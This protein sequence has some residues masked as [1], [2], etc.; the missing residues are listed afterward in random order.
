MKLDGGLP[1]ELEYFQYDT[2]DDPGVRDSA[3]LWIMDQ[4]G[5]IALPR[6][7]LDAIGS[8]WHRPNLQLN[9]I[10]A[11]GRSAN[12]W[13]SAAGIVRPDLQGRATVRT[14]G[15]L[16]FQCHEPFRHWSLHFDGNI[17]LSGPGRSPAGTSKPEPL[18]FHLD[19]YMCAPPWLMGGLSGEAAAAMHS[20]GAAMLMGGVR[21]EQ[22]C[23]VRGWLRLDHRDYP[24]D[25]TGMR[26]RRRGVRQ[27]SPALGHCQLSALFPSGKA[28]GAIVM[29][30]GPAEPPVFSEAFLYTPHEGRTPARIVASP[31]M[32]ELPSRDEDATLVLDTPHGTVTIE[33][34]TLLTILDGEHFEMAATAVLQQGTARYRW[35]GEE[36]IGLIERCALRSALG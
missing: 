21:Y 8:A 7:T 16:R 3:T 28:F 19:A 11:D 18:S 23:R 10:L 24:I 29:A 20:G 35:G 17:T 12:L 1:P 4:G 9:L 6:V 33:G 5:L 31:W 36:T 22:L 27:M 30:Q 34:R 25:G 15:P 2:P 32:T 26:V 14:A 13:T